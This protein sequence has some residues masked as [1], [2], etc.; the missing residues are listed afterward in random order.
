MRV[1]SPHAVRM[2][3]T[4]V[5]LGPFPAL[6]IADLHRDALEL[7]A[8]HSVQQSGIGEIPAMVVAEQIM[9]DDPARLLVV[10]SP[11]KPCAPVAA[12]YVA[13]GQYAADNRGV[14]IVGE[15]S[16]TCSCR[17]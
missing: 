12:R 1:D 10:F 15:V 5:R 11:D 14:F 4:D 16:N 3:V 9:E 6:V 8:D 7:F 17:S 13:L 2:R